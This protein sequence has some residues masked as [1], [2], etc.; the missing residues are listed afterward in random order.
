MRYTNLRLMVLI[1]AYYGLVLKQGCWGRA[2]APP[3][4][5]RASAQARMLGD[6]LLKQQQAA[7]EERREG[8]AEKV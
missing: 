6:E 8:G 2:A 7:A 3:R 1:A 5:L 4:P